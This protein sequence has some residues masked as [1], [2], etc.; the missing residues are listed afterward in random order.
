ME[1]ICYHFFVLNASSGITILF[2][3]EGDD[4]LFADFLSAPLPVFVPILVYRS[5]S[6][7]GVTTIFTW[8][9]GR[10]SGLYNFALVGL[11]ILELLWSY[12]TMKRN[13][14][15]C[16]SVTKKKEKKVRDN[17]VIF[18]KTDKILNTK[19]CFYIEYYINTYI[20]VYQW[21]FYFR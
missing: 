1:F 11:F 4:R 17:K 21:V 2:S 15:K 10:S 8:L 7:V 12:A 9:L 13:N 5:S 3:S 19:C 16:Y 6:L 18:V 20:I 14:H